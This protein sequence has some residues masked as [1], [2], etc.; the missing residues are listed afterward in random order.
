MQ[1]RSN[2]GWLRLVIGIAAIL[3]ILWLAL[4]VVTGLYNLL[5]YIG[6]ILLIA[7]LFMDRQVVFGYG[8]WIVNQFKKNPAVGIGAGILSFFGFP[9]VSA[10][11]F[12]KAML[13]KKLNIGGDAHKESNTKNDGY[14]EYEEL[15]SETI[16]E[17][18]LEDLETLEKDIEE[19]DTEDYENFFEEK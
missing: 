8:K 3:L 16:E 10:F 1:N 6:P 14:T 15:E 18:E 17:F 11:L 4:K 12:G 7:T 9:F 2:P 5:W 13:K 19:L